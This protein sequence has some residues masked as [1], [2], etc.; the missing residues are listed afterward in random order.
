MSNINGYGL[1]ELTDPAELNAGNPVYSPDGTKILFN[2]FATSDPNYHLYLMNSDGTGLKLVPNA[3]TAVRCR[4]GERACSHEMSAT[5]GAQTHERER[6]GAVRGL[7][8]F[9]TSIHNLAGAT[10]LIREEIRD[11]DNATYA[12]HVDHYCP[13]PVRCR[14]GIERA[15]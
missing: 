14:A 12:E 3:R 13:H 8:I 1:R 9:N 2:A 10:N 5:P 4:T 15:A 7:V 11:E 6:Q